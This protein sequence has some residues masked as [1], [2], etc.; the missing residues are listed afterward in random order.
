M[1]RSTI[2]HATEVQAMN[3]E[4]QKGFALM[5]V[6]GITILFMVLGGT[7]AFLVLKAQRMS[8]GQAR[9]TTAQ[10]AADAG[11]DICANRIRDAIDNGLPVTGDTIAI[12]TYQVG[13]IPTFL[14]TSLLGGNS[15]ELAAA[16]EGIGSGAG[17]RGAASYFRV[18]TAATR[19]GAFETS[20]LEV[21]RR[22]LVGGE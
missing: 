9:Y 14:N 21:L 18:I 4:N 16:Y 3:R 1:P 13:M 17:S 22:K 6:L 7:T 8:A 10:I 12:G 11:Q 5:M 2:E 20:Q 15:S 19:T